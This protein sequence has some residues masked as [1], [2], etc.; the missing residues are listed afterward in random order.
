MLK[1]LPSSAPQPPCTPLDSG[2]T[3]DC[4]NWSVSAIWSTASPRVTG[5]YIGRLVRHDD[6]TCT[7]GGV[8]PGLRTDLSD[9]IVTSHHMKGRSKQYDYSRNNET[10]WNTGAYGIADHGIVGHKNSLLNPCGSHTYFVVRPGSCDVVDVKVQTSEGT[11]NAYNC[12]GGLNTYGYECSDWGANAGSPPPTRKYEEGERAGIASTN[13]P[14]ATRGYRSVNMF[15]GQEIGMVRWLERNGYNV[16]YDS[17]YGV[18]VRGVGAKVLVSNGHDEYWGNEQRREVERF[19]DG[20]G[21]V[22]FNSCNEVFWKVAYREGGRIMESYKDTHENEFGKEDREWT[23]TWRDGRNVNW[24]EA[25]PENELTGVLFMVNAWVNE[26]LKVG[27]EF[28]KHRIWRHTAVAEGSGEV[29]YPPGILGHELDVDVNNGYRPPGLHHISKT[30]VE[31]CQVLLDEGSTFSTGTVSHG[32]TFYK[33]EGRS[34]RGG[35]KV[36]GMGTCQ[37]NWGLDG[38]H[39]VG[40]KE[41]GKNV[42]SLRVG[43]DSYRPKGE[44][45]IQQATL[46]LL[47]DMGARPGTQQSNLVVDDMSEG[48][49]VV[50]PKV[51]ETVTI[52]EGEGGVITYKGVATDVGGIVAG[53]EVS[54]DGGCK[55]DRAK[56]GDGGS[57]AF[58]KGS[59]K[60]TPERCGVGEGRRR[61]ASTSSSDGDAF[62]CVRAVDDSGNLAYRSIKIA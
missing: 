62:I 50:E 45:D 25:R 30:S 31:H 2:K 1:P 6:Q 28:S 7:K 49:D 27:A 52:V 34:G 60:G 16:G 26:A 59:Y 8:G 58:V 17:G 29:I 46:N 56:C 61:C 35:G 19:R 39:D 18:G 11:W 13:R 42:Y 15:L 48:E 14:L 10:A 4:S 5:V 57:W 43:L 20:G 22:V 54:E 37:G 41:S 47:L 38:C 23:G 3:V 36:V 9:T 21:N 24:E 51:G 12:W 33:A 32:I 40:G 55:W 44:R 53:V